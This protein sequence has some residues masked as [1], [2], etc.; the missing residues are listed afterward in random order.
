LQQAQSLSSKQCMQ[1]VKVRL[2]VAFQQHVL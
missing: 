2:L 1:W